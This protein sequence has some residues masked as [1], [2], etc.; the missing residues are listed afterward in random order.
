MD[1]S[2]VDAYLTRIGASRPDRPDSAALRE[3]HLRHLRTVPFENLA[4]HLGEDISLDEKSLVDKVVHG[5]RGGFCYE[6]NGLFAGLL[7]ALGY[8][9]TLLAARV[10]GDHGEA[11]P[12]FDHLA[13]RVETPAPW[14]VDVGFGDHSHHP[15]RL[16]TRREQP[17]PAGVFTLA[18]T[19]D[20][21]VDVIRDGKPRYRLEPHPRTLRDFEPTCWW[22]RT[23]PDSHFTHR[24]ICSLLTETG[25]TTISNRTLIHTAGAERRET[26]LA[27]DAALLAAYRTHFGINLNTAPQPLR[28]DD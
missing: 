9:V 25:R 19:A 21:D 3:L 23:S 12:P 5:R 2:Q 16:G 27:T 22:Q 24:A 14:L 6:L 11:G 28:T 8:R 7:T 17:D 20:G 4:I 10:Y 15:L 1:D 26:P 18:E 13:L